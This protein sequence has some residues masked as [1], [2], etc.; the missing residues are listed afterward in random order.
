MWVWIVCLL[1]AA[2]ALAEPLCSKEVCDNYGY[3]VRISIKTALGDKAYE[4]NESEMFLFRA[5]VAFAMR[6]YTSDETYKL[7]RNR[8]NSAFLLTDQTLQFVGILPTLAPPISYDTP[9]WLIVF[10][11]VMG[12]V[13]A[14]IIT[15]LLST[16]LKRTRSK[17]NLL[18]TEEEEDR[19]GS[20]TAN[21]RLCE[22]LRE[23]DP[24]RGHPDDVH[25][26]KL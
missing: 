3:K 9:P 6:R 17:K 26:S 15:L 11:V 22:S 8:I 13:C 19:R 16:L 21:G 4:W 18:E 2:P 5:T 10:G 7:S 23:K 12:V 14:G 1:T 25:L 20:I 24:G